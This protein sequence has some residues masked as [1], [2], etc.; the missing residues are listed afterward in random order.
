MAKRIT[1]FLPVLLSLFSFIFLLLILLGG[2][3]NR[4]PD[5]F[6]LKINTSA[7][8]LPSLLSNADLLKGIS[9]ISGNDFVGGDLTA[10]TLG[11]ADE[12]T[13]SLLTFCART[14]QGPSCSSPRTTFWFNPGQELRLDSTALRQQ[15]PSSYQAALSSYQNVAT[16]LLPGALVF[17]ALSTALAAILSAVAALGAAKSATARA[18]AV[19]AALASL[20]LLVA[21]AAATHVFR[22]LNAELNAALNQHG[23]SSSL[24]ATPFALGW[25]AMLLML[26]AVAA[27]FVQLKAAGNERGRQG[28]RTLNLA[29]GEKKVVA[30]GREGGAATAATSKS[31]G[32]LSRIPGLNRHNYVQVEAQQQQQR[33]PILGSDG[34]GASQRSRGD[35][36]MARDEYSGERYSDRGA[37]SGIAMRSLSASP[38]AQARGNTAYEPYGRA[39]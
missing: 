24:G 26:S 37:D 38:P 27:L 34:Y 6:Y 19:F 25:L 10:S 11:L 14:S 1:D 5:I 23:L 33:N 16:R 32:L 36:W 12:Y 30:G 35:D 15:Y 4:L 31:R 9:S 7:L 17:C 28:L 20:I 2:V 39:G 21:N 18:A 3:G 29:A 13:V 8:K 22:V